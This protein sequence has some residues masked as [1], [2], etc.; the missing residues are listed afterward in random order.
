MTLSR[1]LITLSFAALFPLSS[2]R[3]IE[4]LVD[5][6]EEYL[7][8][9]IRSK[10][11]RLDLNEDGKIQ[12]SEDVPRWK[13]NA[14]YDTN[15]DGALDAEELKKIPFPS[16]DSPGKKLLNVCFKQVGEKKIYLDFY[17]P[18]E[19]TSREKPVIVFTHGGGWAAGNKSKA[20]TGSFNTIHRALLKEGFC[21]L[22]VG[23]RLVNKGGESSVRD[24]VI[25]CQDALR[26]ISAHQNELGIDPKKIYPFGDSA[27]GH[28]AQ[29]LL[30]A[31]PDHFPGDP[32]LANHS[33]QTR[34]GVSWYGPCDFEKTSLFNHDERPDFKDR[35]GARLLTSTTAPEEKL[36]RYREMSPIQYLKKDSPPLLMIQGDKDTTIPVKHAYYMQEK[37]KSLGAPV[38]IMIIKNA[39]HNWRQVDAP[40]DPTREVISQRTLDFLTNDLQS[41]VDPK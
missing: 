18:D 32:E 14:R 16:I 34:A 40:I 39:G 24:C 27:G 30:L 11:N 9:Q 7:S 1:S 26:F 4:P 2:A 15:K 6:T 21:V 5:A 19:D 33:Y 35:F 37:A 20:G 17:F 3:A 13:Q 31:P 38:E 25:D 36:T 8:A 23:Y 28:L 10:L 22:S 12:K 41:A 29:M